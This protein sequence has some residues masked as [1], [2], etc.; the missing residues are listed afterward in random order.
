MLDGLKAALDTTGENFANVAWSKAPAGD[1]GTYYA[2]GQEALKTDEDSATETMLRGYVD[3]F[4]RSDKKAV[5]ETA[6]RSL[7]IWWELE[8]I[9]FEPDTGYLHYEWRWVDTNGAVSVSG[10]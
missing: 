5:I 4:C 2:D 8:S 1:Y 10:A 3:F 7:G 6:L 9:Q